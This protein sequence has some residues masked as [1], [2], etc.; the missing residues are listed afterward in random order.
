MIAKNAHPSG[1]GAGPLPD[2]TADLSPDEQDLDARLVAALQARPAPAIPL[3][4]AER[5]ARR[6]TLQTA[7]LPGARLRWGLRAALLGAA[8]SL[9]AMFWL[10]FAT[11]RHTQPGIS[12]LLLQTL[13]LG[14]FALAVYAATRFRSLSS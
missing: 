9:G 11:Q 6:A 4:F 2:D 12:A 1:P 13:Y 14:E 3:H 10:A 7:T 8:I 5:V